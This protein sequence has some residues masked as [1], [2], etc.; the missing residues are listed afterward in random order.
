[1][2]L[3]ITTINI[4]QTFHELFLSIPN[5]EE[6][7]VYFSS[8]GSEDS[9]YSLIAINPVSQVR[10]DGEKLWKDGIELSGDLHVVLNDLISSRSIKHDSK[11]PFLGG[12]IGS[13]DY[14]YGYELMQLPK[15]E[16]SEHQVFWNV[17]DH[18]LIFD[19]QDQQCFEIIRDDNKTFAWQDW[20]QVYESQD[21]QL[22]LNPLW[23]EAQYSSAFEKLHENIKNGEIYQACLTFPFTGK[24]LKKPRQKFIEL[25]NKTPAP[26]AAY[27]E[28]GNRQILSLSPERFLHWDGSRIES[29]PIKGTRPRSSDPDEDLKLQQELLDNEK[30]RAELNMITDLLRNDLSQVCLP[31]TV[32]VQV[33]QAIQACPTVW[34][35]YSHIVGETTEGRTAW[36]IILKTFPG[37]SI[38]GC[39]KRR[40]LEILRELEHSSRGIYTGCIGYI[41]D[42]GQMDLNI[43]IR[44]LEN[45]PEEVRACFGGGIVYDSES[46]KEYRECYDKARIFL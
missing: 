31:G 3:K 8:D 6:G 46:E 35:T 21:E 23:D 7:L 34:H 11:L 20:I 14:E 41:S 17:Y 1:M 44:T 19:H 33:H 22:H 25:I 30:E 40:A 18:L 4:P 29:K 28:Q 10:Y 36:D 24:S 16:P 37:G 45:F 42:H 38:S 27:L 26:M 39:P 9:R 32:K 5:D 15:A 43:A 12:L 2:S 13:I